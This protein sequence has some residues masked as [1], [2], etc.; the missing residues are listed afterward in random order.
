M[1]RSKAFG[2]DVYR[3]VFSKFN[4]GRLIS[5]GVGIPHFCHLTPI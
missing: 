5:G 4:E 1:L 3:I 2:Q